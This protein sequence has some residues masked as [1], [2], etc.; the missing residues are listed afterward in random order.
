MK[1]VSYLIEYSVALK[2]NAT[3]QESFTQLYWSLPPLYVIVSIG[4]RMVVSYQSNKVQ[5]CVSQLH[6]EYQLNS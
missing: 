4:A 6:Y 3:K 1:I 2:S 5:S